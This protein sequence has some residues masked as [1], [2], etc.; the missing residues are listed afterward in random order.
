ME[1]LKKLYCFRVDDITGE[2][3]RFYI[4]EYKLSKNPYKNDSRDIFMFQGQTGGKDEHYRYCVER[5]KL[6]RFCTNKLFTFN[7]SQERATQ[8]IID[9]I[10]E[11]AD[12]AEKE[13]KRWNALLMKI[14]RNL[15]K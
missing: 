1:K 2:I 4:S 12:K 5:G 13:M 8:L 6:D 15:S 3:N 9:C 11:K 14:E 10:K 7:S